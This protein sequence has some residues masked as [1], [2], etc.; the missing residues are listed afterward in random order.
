MI[1]ERIRIVDCHTI[2][3]HIINSR[4]A[5]DHGHILWIIITIISSTFQERL[6]FF[7]VIWFKRMKGTLKATKITFTLV[8][9]SCGVTIHGIQKL[10]S[11]VVWH[12][13]HI[14]PVISEWADVVYVIFQ[15]RTLV[16]IVTDATAVHDNVSRVGTWR[17]GNRLWEYLY[18]GNQDI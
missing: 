16:D 17:I 5:R 15:E 1:G 18:N 3:T 12:I 13:S 14:D 7:R 11:S 4:I 9:A 8:V 2:I 6:E 10:C